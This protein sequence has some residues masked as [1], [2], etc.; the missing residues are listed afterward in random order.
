MQAGLLP[1][2]P[3]KDG[4]HKPGINLPC[5][6]WGTGSGKESS[7]IPFLCIIWKNDENARPTSH[8][9]SFAAIELPAGSPHLSI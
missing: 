4:S 3:E 6:T 7:E 8:L 2:I 5:L 9:F 1:H